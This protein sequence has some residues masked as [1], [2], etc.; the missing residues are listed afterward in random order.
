MEMLLTI[1]VL[2]MH[3]RES[4]GGIFYMGIGCRDRSFD[5]SS[6]SEWWKSTYN[7][8]G[9]EVVILQENLTWEQACDLERKMITFYGRRDKGL[10][11]LVNMTDGGDG[12]Q[13]AVRSEETKQKQRESWT[14][15]R[16]NE[17]AQKNAG[18]GNGMFNK[19]VVDVWAEKHGMEEATKMWEETKTKMG[20]PGDKNP[21]KRPE[22]RAKQSE[23]H[24]GKT[25]SEQHRKNIAISKTGVK[26]S[27]EQNQKQSENTKGSKNPNSKLTEN[28]VRYIRTNYK[29]YSKEFGMKQLANMFGVSVGTIDLIIRN[30]IWTEVV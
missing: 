8:Y 25:K 21:S 12:A 10:G 2:Y 11:P 27:E 29:P 19:S 3:I 24:K 23:A 9:R 6:R 15:D 17:W 26:H 14:E 13:G 1:Y 20:S 5:I 7:L 18:S 28:N 22:V 30:K 4:D 16:R